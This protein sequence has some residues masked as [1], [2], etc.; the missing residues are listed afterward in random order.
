[1][2]EAEGYQYLGHSNWT[3]CSSLSQFCSENFQFV[4]P[5]TGRPIFITPEWE[6]GRLP[7]PRVDETMR[8]RGSSAWGIQTGS[9][10]G[11]ICPLKNSSFW[12]CVVAYLEAAGDIKLRIW[13]L[14]DIACGKRLPIKKTHHPEGQ[15]EEI[16]VITFSK[17][18]PAK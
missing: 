10:A 5:Y 13:I 2:D 8:Q 16:V 17:H 15:E 7:T 11:T 14:R 4:T 12:L 1:M 3:M 9:F 18:I 6:K